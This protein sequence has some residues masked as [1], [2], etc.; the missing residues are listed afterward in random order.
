MHGIARCELFI[1]A[2]IQLNLKIKKHTEQQ[3]FIHHEIKNCHLPCSDINDIT[4]KTIWKFK[5]FSVSQ[6]PRLFSKKRR[7]QHDFAESVSYWKQIPR[8][9]ISKSTPRETRP[10]STKNKQNTVYHCEP[11]SEAF[12]VGVKRRHFVGAYLLCLST[13]AR[14]PL[15]TVIASP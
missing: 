11:L 13:Q 1:F 6:Y 12:S 3:L 7:F 2:T 14:L 15:H 9:H 5:Y 8:T 4:A 10:E